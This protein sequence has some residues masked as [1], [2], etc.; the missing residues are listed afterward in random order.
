MI[1]SRLSN[2]AGTTCSTRVGAPDLAGGQQ[3]KRMVLLKTSAHPVCFCFIGTGNLARLMAP[4]CS[5]H[6]TQ[7]GAPYLSRFQQTYQPSQHAIDCQLAII[8]LTTT[9]KA[10]DQ[11]IRP[12]KQVFQYSA[13]VPQPCISQCGEPPRPRLDRVAGGKIEQREIIGIEQ[14]G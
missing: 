1:P 10:E 5:A 2:S 8:A 3:F 11:K 14:R 4:R 6:R 12:T 13:R 7:R 9:S